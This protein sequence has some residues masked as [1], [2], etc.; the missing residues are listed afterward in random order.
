MEVC[1]APVWGGNGCPNGGFVQY[2]IFAHN[3]NRIKGLGDGGGRSTWW[4]LTPYSGNSS[5]FCLVYYYGD[6]DTTGA[7]GTWLS[8]PV[9][10]RIS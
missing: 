1:G 8:A 3:M 6:A 2:P 10:F 4:E 9:C 7:S 5:Y